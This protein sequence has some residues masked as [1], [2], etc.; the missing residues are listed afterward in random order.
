M[1]AR[2]GVFICHCGKNIARTPPSRTALRTVVTVV[3]E[4]N[5]D[6][7]QKP[8]SAAVSAS[9]TNSDAGPRKMTTSRR[10]TAT[11][12]VT[13]RLIASEYQAVLRALGAIPP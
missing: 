7:S 4:P 2:V 3:A 5:I 11:A 8:A 1:T 6:I 12:A 10:G 13:S 9:A